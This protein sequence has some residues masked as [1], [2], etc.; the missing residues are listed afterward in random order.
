M[1]KLH[2]IL[3]LKQH[4]FAKNNL[5]IAQLRKPLF[6]FHFNCCKINTKNML[7]PKKI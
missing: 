5:L 6:T 1:L 7:I 2:V 4:F 3:S